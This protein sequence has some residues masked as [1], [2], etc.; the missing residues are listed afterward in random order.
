MQKFLKF[1]LDIYVQLNMF[2]VS[3]RPLSGAQQLQ[4]QPLGL[5]LERGGSSVVGHGR[6]GGRRLLLQLLSS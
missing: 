3:S 5:P 4:Y 2:R 1:L 6:A